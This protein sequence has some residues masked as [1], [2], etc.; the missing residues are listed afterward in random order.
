M[1]SIINVDLIMMGIIY[2]V[3]EVV[4]PQVSAGENRFVARKDSLG[5]RRDKLNFGG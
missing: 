2:S 1:M 4:R 3:K 5:A